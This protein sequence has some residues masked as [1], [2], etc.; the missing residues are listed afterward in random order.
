MVTVGYFNGDRSSRGRLGELSASGGDGAISLRLAAKYHRARKACRQARLDVVDQ[1]GNRLDA[2]IE[3][4]KSQPNAHGLLSCLLIGLVV[5]IMR[6]A[7]TL[8]GRVDAVALGIAE[9]VP[10]LVIARGFRTNL[11]EVTATAR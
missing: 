10:A 5:R 4:G 9:L 3:M 6:S 8:A 11:L 1:S 2:A 7:F